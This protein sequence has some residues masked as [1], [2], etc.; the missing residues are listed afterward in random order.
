MSNDDVFETLEFDPTFQADLLS[1]CLTSKDR[2]SQASR[3]IKS[4]DFS[5]PQIKWLWDLAKYS[6][7]ERGELPSSGLVIQEARQSFSAE[8][9]PT[10]IE[11]HKDLIGGRDSPK[12]AI[13]VAAKY[14]EQER[15]RQISERHARMIENGQVREALALMES[16]E[17]KVE[18][19]KFDRR[20]NFG[21]DSLDE[22]T[23]KAKARRDDPKAFKLKTRINELDEL[24]GGGYPLGDLLLVIGWSG[25]GKST[26]VTNLGHSALRQKRGG[27]Y[28]SSEM[29]DDLIAAKFF[30][31]NARIAQNTIYEY[32]FSPSEEM[33]YLDH[34]EKEREKM[35]KLLMIEQLGTSSMNRAGIS[36]AL[37]QAKDYLEDFSWAIIDTLDHCD[38]LPQ[39]KNDPVRGMGANAN[40]LSE[41]FD[42]RNIAGLVTTQSNRGGAE[43]TEMKHAANTSETFRVAQW[44][45][46]V[47]D[48][49]G[50]DNRPDL[51]DDG[52]D[53][54][55]A[56]DLFEGM[57]LS[58][59]K[60][61]M[62]KPGDVKISTELGCSFMGD[63]KLDKDAGYEVRK[64]RPTL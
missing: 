6:M 34:M 16:Q 35:K 18:V 36:R 29:R 37:D 51:E 58:L 63:R 43:R 42:E 7:D 54:M 32:K 24:M 52:D 19:K 47:N 46:A 45:I 1:A 17:W 64:S 14:A 9:L 27:V 55:Q 25:R 44:V 21:Y 15:F 33:A 62:G 61:R 3:F 57:V 28:I 22:L 53:W 5:I 10:L 2:F 60:A 50:S 31:R 40:W 39:Y 26:L 30:A 12:S 13:A 41:E 56:P 11:V 59:H 20:V 4:D 48:L 8:E 23:N 49:E 38:S